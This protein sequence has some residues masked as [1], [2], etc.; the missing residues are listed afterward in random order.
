LR[1]RTSL[2]DENTLQTDSPA[3][4]NKFVDRVVTVAI[5]RFH[6]N[7]LFAAKLNFT[8][9]IQSEFVVQLRH[10]P[11]LVALEIVFDRRQKRHI[12]NESNKR[13]IDGKLAKLVPK[14]WP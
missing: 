9:K 10:G 8:R 5:T 7:E 12:V 2:R 4:F 13:V 3:I 1:C 11:F 14:D 6:V